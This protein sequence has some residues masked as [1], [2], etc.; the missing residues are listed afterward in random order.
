VARLRGARR[1]ARVPRMF[2]HE[3]DGRARASSRSSRAPAAPRR[4][5]G[6]R[7]CCAS[8]CAT[9][10]ARGS[11]PRCSTSRRRD[12]R[13][14]GA[15]RSRSTASTRTATCA[16]RPACIGWCASRRS[17]RAT[18]A[19]PRSR[20]STCTRSRRLD[21][22]RHQSPRTCASTSSARRG[23]GGQHVNKTESAVR[24]THLPTNIVVQCQNDRSQHRNRDEAMQMLRS[25]PLRAR[26][27][28]APGRAG[29]GRGVEDRHRL[30][31]PDPL[32]HPRQVAD[33]GSE[34][35]TSRSA[36][37]GGARRRPRRVHHRSLKQG[38]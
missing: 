8:T 29:Q 2:S 32:V 35:P 11:R 25:A 15:R 5:T 16:P 9:A 20:R 31:A 33:Q 38:V 17:V 14:Q 26:A 28:Q 34:R 12:R 22:D 6:R 1:G 7:C 23:A 27:A 18:C 30:G 24:I 36:T 21:T 10:S 13:H 3:A 4:R 19:R 37:Q